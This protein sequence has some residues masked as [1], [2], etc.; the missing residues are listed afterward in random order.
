MSGTSSP[1]AR[2]VL[3][4]ICLAVAGSAVAGVHYF[5]VELPQKNPQTPENSIC[6]DRCDRTCADNYRTCILQEADRKVCI[7]ARQQ[8]EN[9]C[10]AQCA[11]TDCE[12]QCQ[13]EL[14]ACTDTSKVCLRENQACERRCPC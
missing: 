10:L 5:A 3:F 12:E 2:L 9:T 11:C 4:M 14:N 7:G 8:C 13:A 1:L 6:N